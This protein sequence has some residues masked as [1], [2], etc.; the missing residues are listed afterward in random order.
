MA[1]GSSSTKKAAKLAQ[2]R[3]GS[4]GP[5]F[6]GGVFPLAMMLVVV[7]GV[8]TIVWARSSRPD[9]LSGPP[10]INDHWHAAYGI[11]I[12]GTWYQ[13]DGNLEDRD[14][15][16]ALASVDFARTGIHSHDDG[17]VHWHAYSSL[18]TGA[19]A[20]LKVFLN[21]YDAELGDNEFKIGENTRLINPETGEVLDGPDEWKEG[22]FS[23]EDGEPANVSLKVWD[24]YSDNETSKVLTASMD[25]ARIE[26]DFMVFGIYVTPEGADQEMPP[27]ASNLP[28]LGS[29]DLA[30]ENSLREDLG[31]TDSTVNPNAEPSATVPD[32]SDAGTTVTTAGG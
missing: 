5:R 15:G 20:K 31:E 17:V 29:A 21:N 1:K 13:F 27:W 2:Q 26:R 24:N 7:I 3:G 19:N 10:T 23:C 11:D 32:S 14:A 4:T 18:S 8:A 22:D 9:G 28:D 12:C 6:Q 30:A 25:Q 16:G